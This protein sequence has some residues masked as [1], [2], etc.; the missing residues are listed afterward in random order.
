MSP[1][2]GAGSSSGLPESKIKFTAK[3]STAADDSAWP[4][5][6]LPR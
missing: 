3:S 2:K 5:I 4:L 1:T 6:H